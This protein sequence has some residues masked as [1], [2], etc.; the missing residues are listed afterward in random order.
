MLTYYVGVALGWNVVR[1]NQM[2][3]CSI[4][5]IYRAKKKVFSYPQT[6]SYALIV[7]L[8]ANYRLQHIWKWSF[9]INIREF[10]PRFPVKFGVWNLISESTHYF[11]TIKRIPVSE[12]NCNT[13]M[14]GE[15]IRQ[16]TVHSGLNWNLVKN[17]HSYAF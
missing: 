11:D 3:V 5:Y 7:S 17:R 13:T 12:E 9:N 15:I 16:N 10:K 14:R 6:A 4:G 1:H 8:K 2:Q